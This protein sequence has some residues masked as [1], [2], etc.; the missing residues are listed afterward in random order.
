MSEA[1]LKAGPS[2]DLRCHKMYWLTACRGSDLLPSTESSSL[3]GGV[4]AKPLRRME[5]SLWT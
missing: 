1:V 4:G 3:G 2:C 5:S